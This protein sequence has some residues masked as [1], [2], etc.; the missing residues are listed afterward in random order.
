MHTFETTGARSTLRFH[1]LPG[2]GTPILFLHGMGCAS[3][4][5]YPEVACQTP[6]QGRRRILVDLLGSGYSDRPATFSYTVEAH[7]QVVVELIRRLGL[8]RLH[9]FGHSMSGAVAIVVARALSR[10]VARLVLSEPNLDPGGRQHQPGDCRP[11]SGGLRRPRSRRP[12]PPQ[13]P[14]G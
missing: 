6:L 10:R 7:A 12:D 9:L 4:A 2:R 13:P 11:E 14:P 1:D 5:D 8:G 3:S